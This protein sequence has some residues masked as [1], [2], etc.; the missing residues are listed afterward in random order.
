[1]PPLIRFPE[2]LRAAFG[3]Y[4]KRPPAQSITASARLFEA[5]KE[6]RIR[7]EGEYWKE[8]NELLERD[9]EVDRCESLKGL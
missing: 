9:R 8:I 5:G 4:F 1:M 6:Q 3:K 7:R 2:A